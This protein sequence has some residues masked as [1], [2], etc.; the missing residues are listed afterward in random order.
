MSFTAGE[1]LRR[2]LIGKPAFEDLE[3]DFEDNLDLGELQVSSMYCVSR[4][5][6]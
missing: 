2:F 3:R 1:S 4:S 5:E 6:G